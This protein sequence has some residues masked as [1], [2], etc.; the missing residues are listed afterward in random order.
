MLA[1]IVFIHQ[2]RKTAQLVIKPQD[3]SSLTTTVIT[4][5][6]LDDCLLS[7]SGVGNHCDPVM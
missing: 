2:R 3:W 7:C 4:V 1:N 6:L 5:C